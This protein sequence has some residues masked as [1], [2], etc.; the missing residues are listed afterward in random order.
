MYTEITYSIYTASP[1]FQSATILTCSY[2]RESSVCVIPPPQS[3]AGCREQVRD[4][5][6]HL[7]QGAFCIHRHRRASLPHHRRGQHSQRWCTNSPW[8]ECKGVL[9]FFLVFSWI[10]RRSF[11][12]LFEH[13]SLHISP[14]SSSFIFVDYFC[15]QR[16]VLLVCLFFFFSSLLFCIW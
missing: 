3:P 10:T 14:S 4:Q 15:S 6:G 7:S 12:L 1:V 13:M 8:R 9:C 16:S 5:S 11:T 2:L